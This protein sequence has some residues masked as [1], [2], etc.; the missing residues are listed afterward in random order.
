VANTEIT[1]RLALDFGLA[2]G[3]VY[4]EV[5]IGHDPRIAGEMIEHAVIAGLLSAD[6]KYIEPEWSD[7]HAC[8]C[9]KECGC[10]S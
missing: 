4:R 2:I 8:S 10:G 5:V 1:P 6:V 3:S 9:S 7:T